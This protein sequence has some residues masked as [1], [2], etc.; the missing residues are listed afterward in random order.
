MSLRMKNQKCEIGIFYITFIL[1]FA[2]KRAK[3]GKVILGKYL[4]IWRI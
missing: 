3:I 4:F 2:I 1:N